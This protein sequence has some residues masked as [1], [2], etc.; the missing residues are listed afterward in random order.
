MNKDK[1]I[2]SKETFKHYSDFLC[3]G[4]SDSRR[5]KVASLSESELRDYLYACSA[6][7]MSI[8]LNMEEESLQDIGAARL[9][10]GREIRERVGHRHFQDNRF[11]NLS[12]VQL[13]K[14][15]EDH[16]FGADVPSSWKNLLKDSNVE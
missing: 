6:S 13:K 8:R 3:E 12:D 11:A 5:D 1:T 14:L 15:V 9:E 4:G 10:R 16:I 7:I 2:I